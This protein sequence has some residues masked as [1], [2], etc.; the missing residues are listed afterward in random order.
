[1]TEPSYPDGSNPMVDMQL[2]L[3][4]IDRFFLDRA[5]EQS[6]S[7]IKQIA[8]LSNKPLVIQF[9]GGRDS[10]ALVGL[11][12]DV[13]SDFICSFMQTGID[14]PQAVDFAKHSARVLD[15]PLL[16]S[17]PSYH[18]GDFFER[19]ARFKTF[20]TIHSTWC[21]RDL[22]IRPQQKMLQ[23]AL[24][25]IY[26]LIGV[27]R[28]ESIRRRTIYE[29]DGFIRPDNQVGG[30][31]NVYPLLNWTDADV[32]NY[33]NIKGLPTSSLYKQYGVSGCY[34]CPFYQVQI[35]ERILTSEPD[36]YDEIIKW[37]GILDS[38]SVIGNVFLKDLKQK[39]LNGQNSL[40]GTLP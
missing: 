10:M 37:E 8:A 30:A 2:K 35:Y 1:M 40:E 19:L 24:G 22:K 12:K 4:T 7:V 27:R 25:K 26:K 11:V 39:I 20:P 16:I 18:L 33:L 32:S 38:P 14:F 15:V 3:P 28:F 23:K 21:N 31:D 6:H 5:I 36:L 34:W 9:S 29:R 13:T 17:T